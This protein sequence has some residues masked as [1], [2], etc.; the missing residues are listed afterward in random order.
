M[1]LVSFA[2]GLLSVWLGY[3]FAKRDGALMLAMLPTAAYYSAESRSYS[4]LICA[5][6]LGVWAAKEDRWR[7]WAVALLFTS[8]AHN[9]GYFYAAAL[10][11]YGVLSWRSWRIAAAGIF[12]GVPAVAWVVIAGYAQVQ[13]LT[14]TGWWTPP[15]DAVQIAAPLWFVFGERAN[16][17]W[18][19]VAA[20]AVVGALV[21][22][23]V[24]HFWRKDRALL[25]IAL[26]V[27]L[28]LIVVSLLW[29]NIYLHRAMLPSTILLTALGWAGLLS[30]NLYAANARAIRLAVYPVLIVAMT[31]MYFDPR[32]DIRAEL[33]QICQDA[34]IIY[35]TSVENQFLTRYYMP[36]M[37]SVIWQDARVYRSQSIRD[38]ALYVFGWQRAQLADLRGQRVCVLDSQYPH[39]APTERIYFEPLRPVALS[40]HTV[41]DVPTIAY[42][43]VL[44]VQP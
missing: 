15:F 31:A 22:P 40:T 44:M 23:V 28:A 33:R 21:V 42:M 10:W 25:L 12:A 14:V 7:W 29:Q 3:R 6:L 32:T 11:L 36:D 4:L 5:V 2:L 13:D 38:E 8:L 35:N 37:P 27:P 19:F 41:W 9:V 39:A 43:R 17:V 1:R 16:G 24:M 34:D 20:A 26:G 30:S 18:M